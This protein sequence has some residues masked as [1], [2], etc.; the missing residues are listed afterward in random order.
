MH[1]V[2]PQQSAIFLFSHTGLVR[3][4]E[5]IGH[6]LKSLGYRW[7]S[8]NVGTHFREFQYT[9]PVLNPRV[10]GCWL[11]EP[12]YSHHS[13]VMRD[14]FGNSVLPSL[15]LAFIRSETGLHD[16]WASKWDGCSPVPGTGR[17]SNFSRYRHPKTHAVRR[18]SFHVAEDLEPKIRGKRGA[19]CM[20]TAWD[21]YSRSDIKL[22]CWKQYRNTQWK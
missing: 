16:H 15:F 8:D 12:V 4:F 19:A 7:I 13:H 3:T 5:S 1:I 17:S 22:R 6:A 2:K 21:D 20:P 9:Q 10:D 14:E 11:D 18:E